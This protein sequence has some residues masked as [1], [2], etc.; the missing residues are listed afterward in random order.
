MRQGEGRIG[1]VWHGDRPSAALI[2]LIIMIKQGAEQ[3]DR[4]DRIDLA[5]L[6]TKRKSCR[7]WWRR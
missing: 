4:F 2:L 7:T 3:G 1:R 5:R 6:L